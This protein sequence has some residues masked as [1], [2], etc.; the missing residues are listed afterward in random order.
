MAKFNV[1]QTV[2]RKSDGKSG[3][4]RAREVKS[5]ENYTDVKYLVDFGD[6]IENWV[7]LTKNDI[8][9]E[10]KNVKS[11]DYVFKTYTVGDGQVVT[12]AAHVESVKTEANAY[13]EEFDDFYTY[14]R[15]GKALSIGF[16]IYNGSD[17]YNEEI[18]KKYAKHRCKVNPFTTMVSAFS[19]EFN[20]DTVEAIMNAKA[21][22]IIENIDRFYRP[23]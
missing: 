17:E 7:V 11:P 6:G 12:M 2:V 19:G 13:I 16:S 4:I 10:P 1:N 23:Q 8:K 21:K 18:G 3:I 5:V 14:T 22:Y 15:K 9:P 20:N